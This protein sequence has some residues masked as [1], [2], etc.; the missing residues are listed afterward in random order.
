MKGILSFLEEH[1]DSKPISF[2]MPGHKGKDFYESLGMGSFD[3][4]CSD[5]D[6]TEISGAD[7]L[8]QPEGIIRETMDKYKKLY[9]SEESFLLINGSSCGIIAAI[10]ASLESG[11]KLLMARNSHK[12]VYNALELGK[13]EPVYVYPKPTREYGLMG[14]ISPED[15]KAALEENP[16]VKAVIVP[17]PNYYGIC[18]DIRSIADIS[19]S[20]GALLIVDQ[21]HGAHLKFMKETMA[22]ENLGA[23]IV[24]NS[25][26]KTLASFTQTAI[27]NLCSDRISK[28]SVAHHLHLLEST[29]PSYLLMASLDVNA[30]IIQNYG[31]G[32]FM[33]WQKNLDFFYDEAM[34]IRGLM[35]MDDPNLDRTKIILDMSYLDLTGS[36]LAHELE[37]RGIF[38]EL[39]D[40]PI[41]M[42]MTGIGNKRYDYE[43][44]LMALSEISE[45]RIDE[46]IDRACKRE[47]L[48]AEFDER[49]D[50]L[51][52]AVF[53]AKSKVELDEI[54]KSL[55]ALED[56]KDLSSDEYQNYSYELEGG[57]EWVGFPKGKKSVPLKD[58]AGEVAAT[59]LTPYPPGVPII[60]PGE[61]ITEEVINHLVALK[62]SGRK[63]TGLGAE[64]TVLVASEITT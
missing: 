10:L 34:W 17:S 28:E 53:Q 1:R 41:V 27:L 5:M 49:R 23:D 55:Q 59:C 35:T 54:E 50:R 18:S 30:D 22:A 44:L 36:R 45:E 60:C 14:Q 25:T 6:I 13:I 63:V 47:A 58:S 33:A 40:G 64:G 43:R 32:L 15:V 2:H 7:N 57:A 42:C 62:A 4:D 8:F 51:K 37:K 11:G 61:V 52:A 20:H 3:R 9:G 39:S 24:I 38:T 48:R 46:A 29:S 19:H 31:Q 21:A 56:E 12:S 26:H 16:D